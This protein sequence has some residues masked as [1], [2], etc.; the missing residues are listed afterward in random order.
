MIKSLLFVLLA[1][2]VQAATWD[3]ANDPSRFDLNSD[4]EYHLDKLPL[5]AQLRTIPWSETYWPSFRGGINARWNTPEH[6]GFQYTPPTREQSAS[7]TLAE[8]AKLSPSEKYDLFMGNYQYPLWTEVR[9]FA[10][11]NAGEWSGLC[12][13]WAMAA[14]QYAE[15]Q[16]LTLPNPDGILIPF[17]SSDVKGL[18]TYAAEFHF[19]RTT[20]QVG[21]ACNTDH[22]QTPEQVL[23]CADMN[24]GALHVILANQIGVKQTGFV[25]ERQPNSEMWNQPTYAYEFA[26]IGSAASD[27]PGMRGVQVH[28]TLYY[29]EDLDESHWEP[30]TGTTNFHFS[31]I[32]MDYVLDLNADGKIVGG[33]WQ[34]GSDHPDYFWMPTNHLEFEGP[35]KGLQSVYKP[36]EH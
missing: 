35:L 13:G 36:I 27:I 10:N 12:D 18:M 33:S 30:V 32:T 22:P 28:A 5:K 19:R 31:K 17:G 20:V 29:S 26:L 15:P 6:D 34:A 25:V 4:Y 23:A 9:R 7:M 14:I 11:P 8:L 1:T 2:S 16:A 21:R 3:S 24:P